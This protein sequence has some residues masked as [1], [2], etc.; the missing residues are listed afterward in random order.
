MATTFKDYYE[1]LGV[2]RTATDDDIKRAYRKLARQFHPDVNPGDQ[3]AEDKFKELNEAYEVLSDSKK[4]QRYDQLGAHW[5]AGEDFTP[6]S[7]WD[8]IRIDFGDLGDASG[9]GFGRGGFS[10]FFEMLFGGQR[11]PGAEQGFATRGFDVETDIS[12]TLAEVHRGSRRSLTLKVAGPCQD[13]R[14]RGISEGK[15]CPA[16]RGAGAIRRPKSLM[17]HI[18][19]GVREGSVI[20][21]AGQGEPGSGH[22]P[23]GD[24]YL[25]VHLEPHPLFTWIGEDDLLLELPVAPWEAALGAKV[26]V[27]TLDGTVEMT[28]PPG[29][30]GAQR[31]RLRGQGLQRQDG[32]RGDLYVRLK[33]VVPPKL[34]PAER[35]LFEQLAATSGFQARELLPG[36]RR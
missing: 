30:Q 11:R 2:P 35:E 26:S 20:R 29:S 31:L 9:M 18:P 17:V 12:L 1:I 14:G 23:A 10:D 6:P 13:C 22:A 28:V 33:V 21:L 7:G 27:P 24:R 25:R 32:R 4:R 15:I 8:N 3:T 19:T 34:T 36:G 5:K 16:C